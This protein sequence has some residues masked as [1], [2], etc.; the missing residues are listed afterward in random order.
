MNWENIVIST[1]VGLVTGLLGFF[2]GRSKNK[3]ETRDTYASSLGKDIASLR[4]IIESWKEHASALEDQVDKQEKIIQE[5][6]VKIGNLQ[7]KIETLE[8]QINE[9]CNVCN[10]KK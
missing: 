5:Q 6:N 4:L 7:T 3:A 10:L 9:Q 2:G 1:G 8:K